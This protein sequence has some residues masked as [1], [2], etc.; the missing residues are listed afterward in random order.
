MGSKSKMRQTLADNLFELRKQFG[1]TQ[2]DLAA[3]ANIP[4]KNIRNYEQ[5]LRWPDPE[6]LEVLAKALKVTPFELI[7]AKHTPPVAAVQT[8]SLSLI[9]A[10]VTVASRMD[11]DK[12]RS[13]LETACARTGIDP[14]SLDLSHKKINLD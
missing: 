14:N 11:K 3:A 1:W 5:Q 8:D 10:L 9:A 2:H 7:G 4:V 6:V 13:I 12:L